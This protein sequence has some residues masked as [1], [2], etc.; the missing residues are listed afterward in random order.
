MHGR[1]TICRSFLDQG[2]IACL[3]F[4][5]SVSL[6][7]LFCSPSPTYPPKSCSPPHQ[8]AYT[9]T[10]TTYA[11]P[12][13]NTAAAAYTQDSYSIHM[14]TADRCC[15]CVGVIHLT[16]NG[17]Q[18]RTTKKLTHAHGKEQQKLSSH[19]ALLPL[20]ACLFV[21]RSILLDLYLCYQLG[22]TVRQP[23]TLRATLL[24]TG[25]ATRTIL[26]NY[27]T[28]RHARTV[29]KETPHTRISYVIAS[30]L[31]IHASALSRSRPAPSCTQ[32]VVFG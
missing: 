11:P 3:G 13:N 23:D 31:F 24:A 26:C 6:V 25:E 16:L 15:V 5:T 1:S 17:R 22:D 7:L 27:R 19:F 18:S 10:Y 20:I 14:C 4:Y 9:H 8:Y 30:H 2:I 29:R 21:L 12:G 28:A 32:L